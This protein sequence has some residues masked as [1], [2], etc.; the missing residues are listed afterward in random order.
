M[1]WE[2][3]SGK[4]RKPIKCVI[5]LLITMGNGG[6]LDGYEEHKPQCSHTSRVREVGYL[7]AHSHQSLFGLL[8]LGVNFPH[9]LSAT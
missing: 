3:E 7:Y 6:A 1:E 8:P 9:F 5:K 2:K 4:R